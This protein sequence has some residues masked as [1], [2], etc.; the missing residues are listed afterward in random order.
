MAV[1]IPPVRP[2]VRG[3]FLR[4]RPDRTRSGWVVA[5]DATRPGNIVDAL[6]VRDLRLGSV[7]GVVKELPALTVGRGARIMRAILGDL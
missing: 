1:A 4:L 5:D 3:K 7:F 2:S 6:K